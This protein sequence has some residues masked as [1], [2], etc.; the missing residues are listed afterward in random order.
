MPN[1]ADALLGEVTAGC[2]GMYARD[3]DDD[4]AGAAALNAHLAGYC[5]QHGLDPLRTVTA[6]EFGHIRRL[7]DEVQRR[8]HALAPGEAMELAFEVE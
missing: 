6:D 5:R 4:A 1:V 2:F 8:W 7:R 3:H